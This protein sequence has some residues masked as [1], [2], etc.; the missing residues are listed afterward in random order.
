MPPLPTQRRLFSFFL[1]LALSGILFPLARPIVNAALARTASPTLAL[2]AYAVILSLSM[3]LIAPLFGLRQVATALSVDRD[4]LRRIRHLTWL[5]GG[6]ATFSLLIVTIPPVYAFLVKQVMGIPSEIAGAGAPVLLV[7]ALTPLLSVGRGYYQG[8]LVQYGRAG[9]IGLGA[10][11]YL[12]GV[13]AVMVLGVGWTRIE[14]AL[15]AALAMLLAQ[16]IY[17]MMVWWP[18]RPLFRNRIPQF[19]DLV[20][21]VQRTNRYVL[22]F[23]L[24]LAVSTVLTALIEPAIQAA[25]ARAPLAQPSLAAYPVCLSLVWLARTPLWNAQQI[26]I[27]QVKNRAAFLLV[28]KFMLI[29]SLVVSLAMGVAAL[30]IFSEWIFGHLIGVTGEVKYLAAQGFYWMALSAF[31]QGGRSLYHGT[32]IGRGETRGIQT[33]SMIRVPTL[34]VAL[35]AGVLYAKPSGLMIAIWANLISEAAEVLV[36]HRRTA[37]LHW[38]V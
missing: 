4:M 2:A 36:L 23:Y 5:L 1:P 19:S 24:P 6:G 32:L 22:L 33:A 15:L 37:R 31:L 28:R 10:L 17:L 25:I 30:P 8:I 34:I 26:V 13:S 35:S 3:P 12:L 29:I 27:A 16:V 9:P 11:G 7:V 21:D 20:P 38:S 18:T 14:G